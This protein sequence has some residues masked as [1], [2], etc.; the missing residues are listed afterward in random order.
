M[1]SI[2]GDARA[3][4]STCVRSIRQTHTRAAA[5]AVVAVASLGLLSGC[6]LGGFVAYRSPFAITV[7][8]DEL[9]VLVCREIAASD[10]NIRTRERSGKSEWELVTSA[11][12]SHTFLKGDS[13]VYDRPPGFDVAHAGEPDLRPGHELS[14]SVVSSDGRG[15]PSGIFTFTEGSKPEIGRWMYVGGEK[16]EKPC[17]VPTQ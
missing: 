11:R 15:D 4:G 2:M 16:S 10:I 3:E 13:L 17:A 1:A 9:V 6:G 7:E 14:V 12:G 5:S 8:D